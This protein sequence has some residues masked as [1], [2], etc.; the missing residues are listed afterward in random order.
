LYF[1][2]CE[3]EIPNL[4]FSSL[5]TGLIEETPGVWRTP[6]MPLSCIENYAITF[7]PGMLTVNGQTVFPSSGFQCNT[8]VQ[9]HLI[10]KLKAQNV[11]NAK[12]VAWAARYLIGT[13]PAPYN[14]ENTPANPYLNIREDVKVA[15]LDE[16]IQ[17]NILSWN[18]IEV[19]E[20]V[21]VTEDNAGF[22]NGTA[23]ERVCISLYYC[24]GAIH[25]PG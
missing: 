9:L 18:E 24:G 25:A 7:S 4:I 2:G 15:T 12:E 5:A 14:F 1:Y 21:L 8:E 13:A 10:A 6:Y 23:Y 16:I 22:I 11:P 3:L 19:T 17:N 20:D